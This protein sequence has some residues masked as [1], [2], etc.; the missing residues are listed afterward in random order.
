MAV[1]KLMDMTAKTMNYPGQSH[2]EKVA[3]FLMERK[4][5]GW[6]IHWA[7]SSSDHS[8]SKWYK[9]CSYLL[10]KGGQVERVKIAGTC[11]LDGFPR[12]RFT[13]V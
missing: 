6:Q 10:K 9:G 8:K 2:N 4:A 5:E 13:P 3:G 7:V 11:W 1:K 12:P